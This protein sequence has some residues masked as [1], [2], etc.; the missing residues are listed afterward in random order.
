MKEKINLYFKERKYTKKTELCN[1]FTIC[2]SDKGCWHNYSTFYDFIF[3]E[4]REEKL[5]VFE[6]G[7]GTNNVDIPSNMGEEGIPGASLKAWRDYFTNSMIYGADIDREILF[8][9][10]RIKTF[11]IDQTDKKVILDCWNNTDLKDVEF[12][13]IIDDGLHDLEPN[14]NFFDCSI[15]KLKSGGI[16][17]IEDIMDDFI[18]DYEKWLNELIS[19]KTYHYVEMISIPSRYTVMNQQEDNRLAII[20]K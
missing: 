14:R 16:Y 1:L 11:Y 15:H 7:L 9:E 8:D 4:N 18:D 5:N 6:L 3:S 10:E 19:T 12:D 17:I 13:V 2:G 20:V